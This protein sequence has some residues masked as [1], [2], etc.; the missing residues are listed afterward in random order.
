[1]VFLESIFSTAATDS[2]GKPKS[3]FLNGDRNEVLVREVVRFA[4]A[5]SEYKAL[6]NAKRRMAAGKSI[7]QDVMAANFKSTL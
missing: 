3:V 6:E 1:M 5:P 4:P 7:F 2:T